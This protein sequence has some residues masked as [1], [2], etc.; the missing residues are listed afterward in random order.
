MDGCT[1]A[2]VFRF[3]APSKGV[4]PRK[5]TAPGIGALPLKWMDALPQRRINNKTTT[6]VFTLKTSK[7]SEKKLRRKKQLAKHLSALSVNSASVDILP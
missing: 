1:T 7:K 6:P 2:K 5:F 3:T 4:L